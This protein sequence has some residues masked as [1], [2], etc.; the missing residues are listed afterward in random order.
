MGLRGAF[1]TAAL[2]AALVAGCGGSSHTPTATQTTGGGNTSAI[3]SHLL[4]SDELAGFAGASPTVASTVST[5]VTDNG[6][7]PG[8]AS[9]EEARLSKLGFV[10][11][12]RE[13]LTGGPTN[14]TDGLSLVE[15]FGTAKEAQSEVDYEAN[16][17]KTGNSGAQ[18]KTFAAPGIPGARGYAELG[19][20]GSG[21]NLGFAKG[22]YAYV[23]GQILP[24]TSSYND[25]LA[26]LIAAA[27]HLYGRVSP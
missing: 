21:I 12:G 10:R 2:S 9:A 4:S 5:W 19:P 1:V 7:P 27:Q 16:L 13:D 6:P 14:T 11:G 15:Q 18:V 23:V 3:S 26:K 24:S 8:G 22:T 17:F 20:G 25:R